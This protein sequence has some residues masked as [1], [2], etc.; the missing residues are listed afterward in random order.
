MAKKSKKISKKWTKE[1]IKKVDTKKTEITLKVFIIK[2]VRIIVISYCTMLI[3]LYFNQ[4]KMLYYPD[5]PRAVSF[6]E[7]Y[8][9]DKEEQNEF[10]WTRFYEKKWT[11]NNV[12]VFFHW[13][14]WRAC[15]RDTIKGLLEKT[16]NSFIFV[17]YFGYSDH[18]WNKPDI[19]YILQ[20]TLN[21]WEYIEG[22]DFDNV[23]VAWR[24]IWTWPASYFAENFKTEKVLLIS[25]YSQLYKVAGDKYPYFPVKIM[26]TQNYNSEEYLKNYTNDLLVIHW[27]KDEVVPFSLWKELYSSVNVVNKEFLEVQ[28]WNHNDILFSKWVGEKIVDF[29]IDIKK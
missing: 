27:N 1:V 20:D 22:K 2:I 24:S 19:E 10:K 12:I 7:C 4:K 13:N 11:N 14:A 26:F 3:F 29:L 16:W 5:Y 23:Y 25:P 28:N 17:E 8:S 21:I 9:F 15:D 6:S 18:W